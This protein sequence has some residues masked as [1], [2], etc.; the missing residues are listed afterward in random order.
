MLH[1]AK[2]R[3]TGRYQRLARLLLGEPVQAAIESAAVLVEERLEL[4][5]GW[6]IDD[7]RGERPWK[8]GHKRS[9]SRELPREQT[10]SALSRRRARVGSGTA[11]SAHLA[12][13]TAAVHHRTA[14]VQTGTALLHAIALQAVADLSVGRD[15]G[16]PAGQRRHLHGDR[17]VAGASSCAK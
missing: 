12:V 10:I 8:G 7:I 5:A 4:G 14:V 6:L 9:I 17:A 11:V 2:Q 13:R 1:Q 3:G 15:D 16:D